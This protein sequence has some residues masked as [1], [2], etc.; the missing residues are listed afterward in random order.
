MFWSRLIWMVR[1]LPLRFKAYASLKH[2]IQGE[3]TE[4]WTQRKKK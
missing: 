2:R 4:K 1:L 3:K